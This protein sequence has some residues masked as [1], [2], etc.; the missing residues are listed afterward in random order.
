[1][2][3]WIVLTMVLATGACAS[4]SLV[5]AARDGRLVNVQDALRNGADPNARDGL[6]ETYTPTALMIAAGNG[7]LE[8]VRALLAAGASVDLEDSHRNTALMAAVKRNRVAVVRELIKAHAKV[9]TVDEN[10]QSPLYAAIYRDIEIVRM[11]LAAGADP[12]FIS[13]LAGIGFPLLITAVDQNK[14]EV[15]RALVAAG[16]DVNVRDADGDT[17]LAV[18][19][20]HDSPEMVSIL[21]NAKN[22]VSTEETRRRSHDMR[23]RVCGRIGPIEGVRDDFESMRRRWDPYS[24]P[25]AQKINTTY[26]HGPCV[27]CGDCGDGCCRIESGEHLPL[28]SRERFSSK[29]VGIASIYRGRCEPLDGESQSEEAGQV[30]LGQP[31]RHLTD[32]LKQQLLSRIPG[33]KK[34]NVVSVIGDGEALQFADEILSFLK[35]QNCDVSGV[36]QSA[37]DGPVV[38]HSIIPKADGFE[39]RIGRRPSP[40]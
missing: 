31:Y 20:R 13:R 14:L 38:G 40:P 18:A 2:R 24:H 22:A 23:G 11:L 30:S 29:V 35:R 5:S 9:N 26:K 1:M 34:V 33:S 3:L 10:A 4:V 21:E 37:F 28:I 6:L 19:H 16:A 12:N 17:A 39:I 15:V 25:A 32:E 27:P 36:D 8:V 7:H